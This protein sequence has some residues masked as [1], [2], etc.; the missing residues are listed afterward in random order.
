MNFFVTGDGSVKANVNLKF[1][2]PKGS[3]GANFSFDGQTLSE[4][5]SIAQEIFGRVTRGKIDFVLIGLSHDVLFQGGNVDENLNA[6]SKYL[7]LC[8]DGGAKPV[9]VIFPVAPSVR[10]GYRKKFVTPLQEILAE[11]KKIY[12][13]ELVDLFDLPL[14]EE[15]FSDA[16]HLNSD[17]ASGTSVILTLRLHEQGIFSDED[18]HGMNYDYFFELSYY[19]TADFFQSLME[20]IFQS[21]VDK[22]RNKDKIKVA[23]VTDHAATWCGDEL[24]NL[25]SRSERFEPT[26]FLCLSEIDAKSETAVK[27]FRHG[28]EKFKARGL[29]VVEVL[30]PEE[31]TPPQDIVIFLRPYDFFLSKSFRFASLTP[32]TLIFY[33]HYCY[34]VTTMSFYHNYPIFRLAWKSFFDTELTRKLFDERCKIGMPRAYSSGLPKMDSFFDEE[35]F[36]F[37]WKMMRPDAK[38]IIWAPHWSIDGAAGAQELYSTFGYNFRFMYEFA[39]AHPETSWVVKPHPEL[40]RA[41]VETKLFPS[42]AAYEDYIQAWNN[43]PNAQFFTGAYYQSI[44]ATS[45]GMIQDSNSFIAEYQFTHKPMIFLTRDAPFTE[46]G[47]RILDA[48]YCVDGRNLD[49]IAALLQKVFIEGNDPLKPARQKVFDELLNYRRVNGMSASEYIFHAVADE[50]GA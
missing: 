28:F 37:P 35:K 1:V 15:Y 46:L 11:L 50:L 23:F 17:G 32:Q 14:P 21:T 45:D 26:I 48:S 38:K 41:A 39:K 4:S 33:I 29:N 8:I 34:E 42:N 5:L 36:S 22:L 30:N 3:H 12:N 49:G 13:F 20:K 9:A 16:T 18:F 19:S 27:E 43:L 31:E 47:E 24:Y 6:L 10:D 44:F 40:A 7:K 25:F 2:T